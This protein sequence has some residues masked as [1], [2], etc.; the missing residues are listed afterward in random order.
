MLN[1]CLRPLLEI[2]AETF[3]PL[4]R[5]N[6][7]AWRAAKNR[8]QTTFNEAAFDR[9]EA[10]YEG[11]LMGYPFRSVAKSFQV[12]VWRDLC[13]AWEALGEKQREQLRA[14]CPQLTDSGFTCAV[15]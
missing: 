13:Q 14:L 8:G 4:M 12:P 6:T 1:P 3:M 9:G 7:A 15:A 10:L 5:Q 11:T 2:I